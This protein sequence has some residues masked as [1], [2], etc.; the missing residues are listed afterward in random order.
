MS[1]I[2]L[3]SGQLTFP[4]TPAPPVSRPNT[5]ALYSDGAMLYLSVNAGPW[6][7]IASIASGGWTDDGGVVRLTTAAD[8]CAVGDNLPLGTEK[9]RVLGTMV[10]DLG[11]ANE[12][13]EHLTQDAFA[14]YQIWHTAPD[15]VL[16]LGADT[17]DGDAFDADSE[18]IV[19]YKTSADELGRIKADRF[20]LTKASDSSQYFFRVDKTSMYYRTGPP[21]AYHLFVN[22]ATGFV[23]LGATAPA[24]GEQLR[25]T[26]A[27]QFD[28]TVDVTGNLTTNGKLV[29]PYTDTGAVKVANYPAVIDDLI[30]VD[31]TAGAFTVTLP[32]AVGVKNRA[33][34][35]KEV[36]G[37]AAGVN[38]NT[39]GGETIDGV[40]GPP[41]DTL[42]TAYAAVT[43]ISDGANWMKFV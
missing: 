2:L 16:R 8:Q 42:S 29:A 28:N 1:S 12:W 35:I 21:G 17:A 20:G 3:L 39:T 15:S 23:G 31:P 19:V 33:I 5:A 37:S 36:G 7:A 38:V 9:L 40:A 32:T 14:R 6:T 4:A 25:V 10:N 34:T 41:A 22:R 27:A 13:I 26:G 30:R 18:G 24:G 43:Y 11:V